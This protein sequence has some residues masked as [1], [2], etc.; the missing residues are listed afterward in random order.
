MAK[1]IKLNYKESLPNHLVRVLKENQKL[2]P[3]CK[4]K[5][6]TVTDDHIRSCG[7]CRSGI[8]ELCEY[9]GQEL[10]IRKRCSCKQFKEQKIKEDIKSNIK[11]RE[12]AEEVSLDY[13]IENDLMIYDA[14]DD[15]YFSEIEVAFD[16]GVEWAFTTIGES[17]KLDATTIL[18]NVTYDFHESLYDNILADGYEVLA[19]AC[20]HINVKYKDFK[21][22]YPDF[23]KWIDLR[24]IFKNE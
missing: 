21:S 19:D 10:D 23:K 13:I 9:C 2:C 16:E 18:E 1:R 5:G 22:Y 14:I 11:T 8:V 15:E 20:N 3:E 12:K 6:F 24:K 4:G 17:I 7:N